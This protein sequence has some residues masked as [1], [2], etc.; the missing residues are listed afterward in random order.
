MRRFPLVLLLRSFLYLDT[1]RSPFVVFPR[2]VAVIPPSGAH[3]TASCIHR[4]WRGPVH[5]PPC[6]GSSDLGGWLSSDIDAFDDAFLQWIGYNA[7]SSKRSP[8]AHCLGSRS[9]TGVAMLSRGKGF[10]LYLDSPDFTLP[11]PRGV[12]LL[13]I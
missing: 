12:P 11:A 7:S 5:G 2:G 3:L 1:C 13:H 4:F 10:L 9:L 6:L 8:L